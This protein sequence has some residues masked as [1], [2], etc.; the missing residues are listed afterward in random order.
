MTRD[1][2][3]HDSTADPEAAK[4][5]AEERELR[6]ELLAAA[7]RL[8]RPSQGL[9][10]RLIDQ[11]GPRAPSEQP[12]GWFRTPA[13]VGLAALGLAAGI[14]AAVGVTLWYDRDD[15]EGIAP[16]PLASLVGPS[17]S[18]RSA[19]DDPCAAR[20]RAAGTHPLIDDFEDLDSMVIAA[21]GRSR[22]WLLS[23]DTDLD[24]ALRVP[25][26][27]PRGDYRRD[28]RY[29]LRL[30]GPKLSD[31]GAVAEVTFHPQR[32]YDA[33]AY[34]GL[35]FSAK[36]PGR[37]LVGAA[38]LRVVPRRWGGTCGPEEQCYNV[39]RKALVLSDSWT[40]FVV[41]WNQ[42]EQAGAEALPLDPTSLHGIRFAIPAEG[43]PFDIMIDDVAFVAR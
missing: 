41:R 1:R 8:D 39:H 28:N 19:A 29:A 43:T 37:L 42:L 22:A 35:Q 6:G 34:A 20:Y 5:T 38:E 21:E 11:L 15:S 17:P 31:W 4:L 33:S 26:P 13:G 2:R 18:A 3:K 32:C 9:E 14:A 12:P 7:R 40:H 10:R 25:A 30:T 36:G 23:F 24:G 16:E 27:R